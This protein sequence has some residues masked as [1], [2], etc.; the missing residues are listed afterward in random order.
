MVSVSSD[1]VPRMKESPRTGTGA[2]PS[3]GLGRA[4]EPKLV[5]GMIGRDIV[6]VFE[7]GLLRAFARENPFVRVQP[8]GS[9]G[10]EIDALA[11]QRHICNF[12]ADMWFKIKRVK[13]PQEHLDADQPDNAAEQ[14]QEHVFEHCEPPLFNMVCLIET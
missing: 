7:I 2:L 3:C 5:I 9:S 13:D 6:A 14:D 12:P 4:S 10:A 1:R 8:V 11:L